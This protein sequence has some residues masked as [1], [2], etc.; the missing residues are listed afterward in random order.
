MDLLDIRTTFVQR[1]GRHDLVVDT[2]DYEDNGANS[3]I[4]EGQRWL[5]RNYFVDKAHGRFFKDV[6]TGAYGVI[7]PDCRV[8]EEVWMMNGD[9]RFQLQKL[10]LNEL[11]GV[12]WFNKP[13][14]TMDTGQPKYY[15]PTYIRMVPENT[16]LLI[17]DSAGLI[18]YMDVMFTEYYN[19]NAIVTFPPTDG[20]YSYDILGLFYHPKLTSD[21][22]KNFWSVTYPDILLMAATRQL[23]VFYRNTEGVNDWTKTIQ[24]ELTNIDFDAV[25]EETQEVTQMEG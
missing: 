7:V 21:D 2:T 6:G 1:S 13:F 10:D 5:D 8:I 17:G 12:N 23:E 9:A 22:Q 16:A 18:G 25:Q 19:F 15:A 3:Y 4:N 20:A 11:K 14:S 24:N